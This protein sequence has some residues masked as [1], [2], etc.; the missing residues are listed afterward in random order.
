[1]RISARKYSQSFPVLAEG[2]TAKIGSAVMDR[3]QNTCT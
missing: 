2:L 3:N 1:L